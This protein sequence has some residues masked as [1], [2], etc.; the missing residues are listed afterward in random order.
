MIPIELQKNAPRDIQYTNDLFK[1]NR[2][3]VR[4]IFIGSF[5][6]IPLMAVL[7]WW[8]FNDAVSG[9][10]WGIGLTTFCELFGLALMMNAKKAVN[11]CQNGLVTMASVQKANITGNTGKYTTADSAGYIF[12]NVIYKENLGREL[13][14]MVS[15]IGSKK[16]IDLKE[17]D[18]VPLLYLNEKPETFILYSE[19]LGI[20]TIGKAKYI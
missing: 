5:L 20:S 12:I 1:T 3:K 17:G 4:S 6:L 2:K 8:K 15:F 10:L 14:G 18:Q 19:S 11:L 9:V 16:E 13:K 7:F